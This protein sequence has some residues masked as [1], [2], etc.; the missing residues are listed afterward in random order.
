MKII[1]SP[2][3]VQKLIAERHGVSPSEV[4]ISPLPAPAPTPSSI[5]TPRECIVAFEKILETLA[6]AHQIQIKNQGGNGFVDKIGAIK[7]WRTL[8]RQG[9]VDAKYSVETLIDKQ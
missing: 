6:T 1:V 8:T 3:E 4:E 9:L 5:P 7:A 2:V